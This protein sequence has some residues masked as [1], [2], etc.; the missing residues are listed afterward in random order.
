V[1]YYAQ[2]GAGVKSRTGTFSVRIDSTIPLSDVLKKNV[3][4]APN[5]TV[6]L[7][8]R[9]EDDFSPK[10]K[11]QLAIYATSGR[12]ET[13]MN[14]GFVP[15]NKDLSCTVK[16][17]ATPGEYAFTFYATNLAGTSDPMP[18]RG[19]IIVL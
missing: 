14:L 13:R 8:Y 10:A 5:S 15:T 16:V 7:K 18:E 12:K 2:S 11:V 6:T 4:T 1:Y 19:T 9:I 3:L 17:G